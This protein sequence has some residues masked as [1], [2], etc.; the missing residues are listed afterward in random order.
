MPEIEFVIP[1]NKPLK[2]TIVSVFNMHD[3]Y[4]HI[5]S[6]LDNHRYVT[7][8]KDYKEVVTES[9]KNA[10]I[11]LT[12]WKK[13]DDYT[14][15]HMDVKI[16]FK[17]LKEVETSQGIMNKGEVSVKFEA[18]VEKDYEEKWE[19]S[20]FTRFI[21]ALNDHFFA[22]DRIDAFKKELQDD[23]YELFN[24]VKAFLGLHRL[25]KP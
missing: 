1:P 15:I 9:G 19:H 25:Q 20:F 24:E 18:K 2:V 4:R 8:E 16:T 3:L 10:A 11:K 21:R 13:V 14:R 23:S 22:S 17:N 6:W 5:R 7:F 12:P